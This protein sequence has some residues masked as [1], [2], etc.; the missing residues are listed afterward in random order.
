MWI[1]IDIFNLLGIENEVSKSWVKTLSDRSG[2]IKE[3]IVGNHLTGRR[4]NI[5]LTAKF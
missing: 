1:G 4:Y 3:F 2:N 5:K